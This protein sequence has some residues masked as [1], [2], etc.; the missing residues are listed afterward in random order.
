M[1]QTGDLFFQ[2][3]NCGEFCDAITTVTLGYK[4]TQLSH[5][6]MVIDKDGAQYI[7]EARQSGVVLSSL[8]EFLQRSLDENKKPRVIVGRLKPKY[9]R[10]THQAAQNMVGWLGMP[11]NNNFTPNNKFKSFYCSQLIA[12]A[13]QLANDGKP[14][15]QYNI[16]TFKHQGEKTQAWESYFKKI[17]KLAPEGEVGTNPGMM[18]RDDAVTIIYQ[19]GEPRKYL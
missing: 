18:S 14:I 12:Q 8:E 4:N 11:Y 6:G 1:P 15:F 7:I 3:L 9:Q 19:Y 13:F 5:V 17:G 10:L 16:M 2:D